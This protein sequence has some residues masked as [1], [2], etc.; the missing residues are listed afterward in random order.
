MASS[1]GSG[2]AGDGATAPAPPNEVYVLPASSGQERLF[3][4]DRHYPGNP[5]W[6]LAV[7]FRLQGRLDRSLLERALNEIVRRHEVLRTTLRVVDGQPSQVIADA[8]P[9][10]VAVTDLRR[11]APEARDAEVDRLSLEEART[12]FDLTNGP[13][14]RAGLLRVG[15]AEY[16]LL[17]TAHH[18]VADYWSVGLLTDEL[19]AL[20]EAYSHGLPSP[21]SELALQ[22]GD[23][24]VWQREQAQ[25]PMV[26]GALAGWKKRLD[27]LPLLEYPTDY[28]RGDAPT[29]NSTIISRLLPIEL[30]DA[31]R[32]LANRHGTT[33]FNTLLAALQI[34]LYQA[35]G[36]TDFGVATQVTGR[37]RVEIEKIIGLFL[38]TVVMRADL[39]GDPR[40]AELLER[41]RESVAEAIADQNPRFEQL[42]RELRPTDYPSHHTLFRVNFICHRDMVRPLEF[43]GV[44]LTG[45]PS[46]SQG[47]LYDLNVFLVLRDEGWRLSCEYNTDLFTPER[48]ERLLADYRGVLEAI[49]AD[50]ARRVSEFPRAELADAELTPRD[51]P[52]AAAATGATTSG[53]SGPTVVERGAGVADGDDRTYAFDITVEQQ[54]I[55]LLDQLVPG[56]P[57]INLQMALRLLGPVDAGLLERALNEV[58]RRHEILRTTFRTIELRPMQLVHPSLPVALAV[59]EIPTAPEAEREAIAR[60]MLRDEAARSFNLASGPLVRVALLRLD[61]H[62]HFLAITMPHIICDGWSNGIVLRELTALYEAYSAGRPSPLPEPPIQ[63]ADFACWQNE[64]LKTADF[65]GDL[66]YWRRQLQGRFPLLD[67]PSDRPAPP[68][69]VAK[70]DTKTL[71]LARDVV[72]SAKEF[73]KREEITPFMLF[74]AVFKTMLSRYTAQD[75]ILVGSPI[76]GRTAETEN[77]VGP[78]AYTISLRTDLAGDPSFR[79]LLRRV[80]DVVLGALEHKDLP[81]ERLTEEIDVEQ[82]Q[83]RN[84]PFQFYFLHEVAFVQGTRTGALEWIPL[85]WLSPG[86]TFDLHLAT[87]ERPEGVVARLEYKPEAFDEATI[88]RMLGHFRA[89]VAAVLASPEAKLSDLPLGAARA[90]HPSTVPALADIGAADG[91]TIVDRFDRQATQRPKAI[92]AWSAAGSLSYDEL[93]RRTSE[94]AGRLSGLDPGPDRIVGVCCEFSGDLMIGA[95]AAMKA[96]SAYV[97]IP[98]DRLAD[99]SVARALANRVKVVIAHASVAASVR[100]AGF[101]ALPFAAGGRCDAAV[102]AARAVQPG[103]PPALAAVRLAWDRD[104]G[105][106]LARVSHRALLA[107]AC[108]GAC[109]LAL[110][111]ADR[112][113]LPRSGVAEEMVFAALISGATASFV[114]PAAAASDTE[115]LQIV[116][117]QRCSVVFV[118]TWRF[119]RLVFRQA[120][121]AQPFF[122]GVRQVVV[123]GE[124]PA[125]AAV[126]A[127]A[128]LTGGAVGWSSVYGG[129]EGGA[130]AAVFQ[131]P[132]DADSLARLSVALGEPA[133]GFALT[134]RDRYLREVP[135]GVPGEICIAGDGLA[136]GYLDASSPRG[137]RFVTSASGDATYFRTGELGRYRPDGGL[138][139]LGGPDEHLKLRG[140]VLHT[141]ELQAALARAQAVEDL[142]VV[143]QRMPSGEDRPV[144]YVVVRAD[145]A[146]SASGEGASSLRGRISALAASEAPY[147][148]KVLAVTFVDHIERREDGRVVRSALPLSAADDYQ[149]GARVTPRDE[150]E[151]R[152]VEIWQDLLGVRP[153][154]ITETFFDLGGNSV[155]AARLFARVK[156]VWNKQVPLATL[157][158]APTIEH[159]ARLLRDKSWTPVSTSLVAI[160]PSGT[161]PPLYFISGIGGNVVRFDELT[162]LLDKEQ[163]VY[164][165]QPPGL[166]GQS[167]CLT[168]VEDMAAHYIREIRRLQP[169][170]PY[171][172]VG[173]SFGGLVTFEMAQQLTGAGDEIALLAMLDAPE[174][175]YLSERAKKIRARYR[176]R[177]YRDALATLIFRPGRFQYLRDQFRRR[178]TNRIYAIFVKLGWSLPQSIGSIQDINAFAA[179]QYRPRPYPG[180][181]TVFRTRPERRTPIDDDTLGWAPLVL[182]GIEAYEVPGDHNDITSQPNVRVLS[183]KLGLSLQKAQRD[184]A[185]GGGSRYLNP[186]LTGGDPDPRPAGQELGALTEAAVAKS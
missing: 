34:A 119:Q 20:Y 53:V 169:T 19:G 185:Q 73:C 102:D 139:Y 88:E 58:I 133:P 115:F 153:I 111:A 141:A 137:S 55:W 80:R 127:F 74:L 146:G 41:V 173:Y 93:R 132:L 125:A 110:T 117:Q 120:G 131:T 11:L 114:S 174:W 108:S 5:S 116:E 152:L 54:P 27:G 157:F 9:I 158:E 16:V 113:A 25:S 72:E 86:T 166:D 172:L 176:L 68:G 30:T 69:P 95:L 29:H 61:P 90:P 21:L 168:R 76:A 70:G 12:R 183:V 105:C 138:E 1:P 167:P 118:P 164:A 51:A 24:A 107:R 65:S 59:L 143:P 148:P 85:T 43:A 8:L 46:K 184:T 2:A 98:P 175:R 48:I 79:E 126:I 6:N 82:I 39:S 103:S 14:L 50:P 162:G 56:N 49:V 60:R 57:A 144:I 181:L 145:T 122:R 130:M 45:F 3:A 151:S 160:R 182:G 81:F 179:R 109:A 40:F 171:Y 28:P 78:F 150:L 37:D 180:H 163:P 35:T 156:A 104:G 177:R 112:I 31:L 178:A 10:A 91:E 15:D 71:T 129:P 32:E 134:L 47:A 4:L 147:C 64:W 142:A 128:G 136:Q 100:Q 67:L 135:I 155:T 89:I 38:N 186:K 63:Y 159:L 165:L 33:L 84:S 94:L 44:K 121:K 101:A 96:G 42:L 23:Y 75:D 26:Q 18:A 161:R 36:Q 154:G 22:Y 13:L 140:V 66:E 62:E 83:G 87:I 123:F 7:R 52:Y 97:W 17:L 99:Q 170:G 149:I 77:V 124:R 106:D 92:A